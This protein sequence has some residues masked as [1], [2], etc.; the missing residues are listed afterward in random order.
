ML[1]IVTEIIK[2]PEV[3]FQLNRCGESL[4][5]ENI[6][7]SRFHFG[8]LNATSESKF[9]LVQIYQCWE[10]NNCNIKRER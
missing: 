3:S 6:W 9:K 1:T 2:D 5:E 8:G 4:R 7:T 10:L